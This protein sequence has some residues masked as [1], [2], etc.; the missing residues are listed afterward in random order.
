[1]DENNQKTHRISKSSF[2]L[3]LAFALLADLISA[4]LGLIVVDGG[5]LNDAWAFLVNASIWLWTAMNGLGWKG[6]LASGAGMTLEIIP[7]LNILPTFT[8][9]VVALFISSRIKETLPLP[10][11]PKIVKK[12]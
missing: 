8:A 4:G 2:Y 1:M 12:A 11:T 6:V 10:E 5:M 9:I 3:M 7:L